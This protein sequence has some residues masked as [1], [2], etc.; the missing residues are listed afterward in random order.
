MSERVGE[1]ERTRVCVSK[2]ERERE[3]ESERANEQEREREHM[4]S[5]L[6]APP[7]AHNILGEQFALIFFCHGT[8]SMD[9]GPCGGVYSAAVL[10]LMQVSGVEICMV[11]MKV[12]LV[13]ISLA[14]VTVS[15]VNFSVAHVTYIGRLLPLS[16]SLSLSICCIEISRSIARGR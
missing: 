11:L 12:P 15:L 10:V 9:A 16:L 14:F 1:R 2:R 3:R 13:L 7:Q 4:H 8:L 6:H 5:L